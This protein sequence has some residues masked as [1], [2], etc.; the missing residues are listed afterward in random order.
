MIYPFE[1]DSK[2]L[3]Y[4]SEM[5]TLRKKETMFGKVWDFDCTKHHQLEPQ[6]VCSDISRLKSKIVHSITSLV[7]KM[8]QIH[9][10]S[11]VYN[12]VAIEDVIIVHSVKDTNHLDSVLFSISNMLV[13][14]SFYQWEEMAF[15]K[16]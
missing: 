12:P 2:T 4:R 5:R 6:L 7:S 10:F 11:S 3:L 13:I 9:L 15:R 16:I 8:P 1:I 14:Y